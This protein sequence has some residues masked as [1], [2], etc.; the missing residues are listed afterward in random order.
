MNKLGR[1]QL[2]K[3]EVRL[4]AVK[5]NI[6]D[7]KSDLE[8]VCEDEHNSLDNME[9]FSGTDRYAAMEDAADHMN[10]ALDS[11]EEAIENIDNAITAVNEAGR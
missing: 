3:I 5:D 2:A 6:L 11:L 1:K 7:I 8:Y 10:D 4:S 9:N